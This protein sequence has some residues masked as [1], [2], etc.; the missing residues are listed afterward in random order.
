MTK[1]YLVKNPLLLAFLFF[2]DFLCTFA[3]KKR[4][5]VTPRRILLSNLAH[6]GDVV[7]STAVFQAIKEKYPESQIGFLGASAS[8]IILQDHPLIDFVHIIDHWKLNRSSEPFL[9][10]V[11]KYILQRRKAAREIRKQKYDVAIDLYPYF[12]NTSLLFWQAKIPVRIGYESGGLGKLFTHPHTWKEQHVILAHLDLLKDVDIASPLELPSPNLLKY[13]PIRRLGSPFLDEGYVVIHMGSAL[14]AKE[15]PLEKW[16]EVVSILSEKKVPIVFTGRGKREKDRIHKILAKA[17]YGVDLS[18][19]LNWKE[20]CGII[21]G[22][23]VLVGVDS[24]AG[25]IASAYKVPTIVIYTGINSIEMWKPVG[26][27]DAF[28]SRVPCSPCHR[29]HGCLHMTCIRSVDTAKVAE[30][31]LQYWNKS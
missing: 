30:K 13:H 16:A 28:T 25:H 24:V 29:K 5:S 4:T 3:P 10:K 19:L 6:L 18:D 9:K 14:K 1:K 21:A 31:V 2:C 27:K 8:E 23:K 7:L 11:L 20:F 15:W 17:P 26:L 22:A 12:P